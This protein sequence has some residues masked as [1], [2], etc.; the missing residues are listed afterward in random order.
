MSGRAIL[1]IEHVQRRLVHGTF[2]LVKTTDPGADLVDV[3]GTRRDHQNTIKPLQGHYP[4][5]ARQ[6]AGTHPVG[7]TL[8]SQQ[9]GERCV[10]LFYRAVLK[11]ENAH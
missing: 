8:R 1:D 3:M 10:Y 11:R 9:M 7:T 6:I 5:N 4:H 2:G